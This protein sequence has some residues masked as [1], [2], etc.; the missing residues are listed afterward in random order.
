MK[1]SEITSLNWQTRRFRGR[2]TYSRYNRIRELRFDP[3]KQKQTIRLL[4]HLTPTGRGSGRGRAQAEPS[5]KAWAHNVSKARAVKS[6]AQAAAL[7]LS[8]AR[9]SL[10]AAPPVEEPD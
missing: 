1:E 7:N 5:L 6:R 3:N 10:A 8:R 4:V 2:R 9:T